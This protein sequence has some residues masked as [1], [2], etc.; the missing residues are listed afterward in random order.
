ML[1]GFIE[2]EDPR[3]SLDAAICMGKL[4]LKNSKTAL[5]KLK[6][7]IEQNDDWQ[8]KTMALEALVRLFDSRGSRTVDFILNQVEKAPDWVSRCAAVKLL[9]YLGP[10]VVCRR[11]HI[12]K[13][14]YLLEN[15][16]SDDPIREVRLE[17]GNAL[18]K[19]ELLEKT[20]A[21]MSK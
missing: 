16:L 14:Y 11:E 2:K 12:E 10:S 13:L 18:K 1:E 17:I 4:G 9:I 5:H 15:R 7:V 19:L 6:H 3:L 8:E 21:R 20:F